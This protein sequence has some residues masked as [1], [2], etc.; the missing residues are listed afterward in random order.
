MWQKIKA[1]GKLIWITRPSPLTYYTGLDGTVGLEYDI[2]SKFC[3]KYGLQLQIISASSN[4]ELF[5]M[6][7][8]NTIDIAGAN[9]AITSQRKHK[10]TPSV[11]Y[12]ETDI[13]IVSSTT[14]PEI[15]SIED[16]DKFRG[17]VLSHSSYSQLAKKIPLK[18]SEYS[19]V[20]SLYE[21]LKQVVDGEIDYTLA[22]YN[23]VKIFKSYMPQLRISLKLS[24][25][26]ELGFLMP[27][28]DDSSVKEK[29]DEQIA[30]YIN[31]KQLQYYKKYIEKNMPN[32]LPADTVTF[33]KNYD[34]RWAS[35]S[36][37]IYQV[38]SNNNIS[39][40]LLGAISYQESHWN[41]KAISPTLVKGLMMLTKNVALEQNVSD[42]S[43][44]LQSLQGGTK[45]FIKM[46]S[47]VPS[48]IVDPDRTNFAL[49][50]YN[51][52]YGFLE[53]ARV[54]TQKAGKNPDLW[55]DVR[56]FLIKF[57][58]NENIKADGKTAV[59]YVENIR[60]YQN[61]LQWKEQQ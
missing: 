14:Y 30:H 6:F 47:K 13:R 9:L 22:D 28:S 57:N 39:P 5:K 54:M 46:L 19:D 10:F 52:G 3:E 53:K 27:K 18:N 50:G 38:A 29:L 55:S 2:L 45:Y 4:D 20:K 59:R 32:S 60:V 40:I 16:I 31:S 7:D 35:I 1:K 58:S 48:R 43:D 23:S 49:A 44:P 36:S 41:P 11:A 26:N 61:L 34:K 25:V 37:L 8:K 17:A 12:D 51:I 21:L 33:L 56:E 15:K 24:E 42:R